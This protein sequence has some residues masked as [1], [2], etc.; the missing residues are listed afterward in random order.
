MASTIPIAATAA[1]A[2]TLSAPVAADATFA[3]S[4]MPF[5]ASVAFPMPF[6]KPAMSTAT[7]AFA[8]PCRPL[9]RASSPLR[10]P[11]VAV[12]TG[13]S[14]AARASVCSTASCSPLLISEK[15][16]APFSIA[17]NKVR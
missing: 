9:P 3:P 7:N 2:P 12:R 17:S 16:L 5:M 15:D 8:R 6:P 14:A 11:P 13:P 10:A 1:T 4:D